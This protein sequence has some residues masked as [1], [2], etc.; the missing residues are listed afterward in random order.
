MQGG[1]NWKRHTDHLRNG[2]GVP[3][4]L[5]ATNLDEEIL[6]D[7][8]YPYLPDT[9]SLSDDQSMDY[10]PDISSQQSST[11]SSQN[12]LRDPIWKRVN[13]TLSDSYLKTTEPL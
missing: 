7:T 5:Q 10:S 8:Y 6:D 9:G 13:A 4:D 12:K 3:P 1:F 2:S 11:V